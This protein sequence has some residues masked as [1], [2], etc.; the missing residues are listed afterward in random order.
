[1]SD[2][3]KGIGLFMTQYG[4]VSCD[5]EIMQLHWGLIELGKVKDYHPPPAESR[6]MNLTSLRP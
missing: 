1:M 6:M 2:V 4:F 5:F 3:L